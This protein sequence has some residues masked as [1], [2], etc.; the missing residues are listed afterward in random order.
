MVIQRTLTLRIGVCVGRT[1][2]RRTSDR[3]V[4]A[5]MPARAAKKKNEDSSSSARFVGARDSSS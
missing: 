2:S 5:R 4:R 1:F 3:A